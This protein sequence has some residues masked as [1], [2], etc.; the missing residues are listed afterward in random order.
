M[1]QQMIESI[2]LNGDNQRMADRHHTKVISA[3]TGSAIY[4]AAYYWF[5]SGE[6]IEPIYL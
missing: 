6:K 5:I 3:M 2:I 1:L 4:S